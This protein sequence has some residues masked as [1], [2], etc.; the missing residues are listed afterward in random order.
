MNHENAERFLETVKPSTVSRYSDYWAGLKPTTHDD[1]LRR[2]LFAFTSVH[3]TW[4]GNVRGYNALKD[5]GWVDDKEDLRTRLIGARCGMFN[6]RTENIWKFKNQ[7]YANP[8]RY[9]KVQGDWK[10][11]RNQ[12][13]KDISGLGM[14]KVSFTLEMLFPIE[15]QVTCIDTHGIQLYELP[16]DGWQTRREVEMYESVEKHWVEASFAIGAS[17]AVTRGIFWDKKQNRRNPR[18]WTYVLEQ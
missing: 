6:G 14:A 8:D 5:L 17:P 11:Y 13:V 4:S 16:F 9:C 10:S 3:T 18:Y 12:L 1:F 15:T 7:F 2:Y